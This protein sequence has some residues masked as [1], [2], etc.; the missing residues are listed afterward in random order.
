MHKGSIGGYRE[1]NTGRRGVK[2]VGFRVL[3]VTV[4]KGLLMFAMVYQA[5]CEG[6]DAD[7][8]VPHPAYCF[9]GL[10]FSAFAQLRFNIKV[11]NS[12]LLAALEILLG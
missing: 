1:F 8:M 12:G 4:R 7:V 11:S 6:N 3:G 5:R 10:G 9:N 2:G